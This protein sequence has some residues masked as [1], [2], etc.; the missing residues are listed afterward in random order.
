MRLKKQSTLQEKEDLHNPNFTQSFYPFSKNSTDLNHFQ[1]VQEKDLSYE[2]LIKELHDRALRAKGVFLSTDL[3]QF[4]RL[5][6]SAI[7]AFLIDSYREL[8]FFPD[9]E[10]LL[11]FEK[12]GIKRYL[13]S[14]FVPLEKIIEQLEQI[15]A[16]GKVVMAKGPVLELIKIHLD[17]QVS[18]D[19]AHIIG[20]TASLNGRLTTKSE[21]AFYNVCRRKKYAGGAPLRY[22][23]QVQ[24]TDQIIE[25]IETV[26]QN[27]KESSK[28]LLD[29]S[30]GNT[31]RF[32]FKGIRELS[33]FK[34]NNSNKRR[35]FELFKLL[36][37]Q[38]SFLSKREY[39]L[40]PRYY[41]R[42]Y[43]TY[44]ARRFDQLTK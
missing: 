35:F 24:E 3:E 1:A 6:L 18:N 12:I 5:P 39:D 30:G 21:V 27:K 4:V 7:T 34:L 41:G 44:Q 19:I 33:R 32:L 25:Q 40:L 8:L 17:V 29:F 2:E 43:A 10:I 37:F 20:F 22:T 13:L 26:T 9:E 42:P 11:R 15:T 38:H 28:R 16:D 23:V 14:K 31:D 36:S